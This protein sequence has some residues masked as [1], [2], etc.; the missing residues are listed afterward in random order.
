MQGEGGE[1]GGPGCPLSPQSGQ[2]AVCPGQAHV[3]RAPADPPQER[4]LVAERE[5]VPEGKDGE[6]G[7]RRIPVVLLQKNLLVRENPQKT[8]CFRPLATLLFILLLVFSLP[9]PEI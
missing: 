9:T 8:G 1:L 4:S 7:V 5:S 6:H 3:C 2:P